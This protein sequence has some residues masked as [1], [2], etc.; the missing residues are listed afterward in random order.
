MLIVIRAVYTYCMNTLYLNIFSLFG[1]MLHII[2][3]IN[4]LLFLP[5]FI[6]LTLFIVCRFY[7]V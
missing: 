6:L 3:A 1:F 5:V 2:D 7:N 4:D